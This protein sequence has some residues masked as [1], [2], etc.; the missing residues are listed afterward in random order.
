MQSLRTRSWRLSLAPI[1]LVPALILLLGEPGHGN[2]VGR[3]DLESIWGGGSWCIATKN[4]QKD[5]APSGGI[6][7]ACVKGWDYK[8]CGQTDQNG[9]T[10]TA[11]YDNTNPQFCGIVMS[12]QPA[13]DGSCPAGA[14][15]TSGTVCTKIPNSVQGQDCPRG[16]IRPPPN[17]V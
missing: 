17:E 13:A 9:F 12:G 16:L 11:T 1:L 3:A 4:C 2:T 5:C 10:C 8:D 6:C 7:Q 15:A 14:C